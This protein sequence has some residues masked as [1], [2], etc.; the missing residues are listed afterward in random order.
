MKRVVRSEIESKFRQGEV[1]I[2]YSRRCTELPMLLDMQ[3]NGLIESELVKVDEQSS[4][5]EFRWK[6][7]P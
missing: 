7:K 3:N 5:L 2:V 4:Y 6:N 1:L